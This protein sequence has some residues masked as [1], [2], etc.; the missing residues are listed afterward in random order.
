MA[1]EGLTLNTGPLSQRSER[2]VFPSCPDIPSTVM[3]GRMSTSLVPRLVFL[4]TTMGAE[5]KPSNSPE[6]SHGRVMA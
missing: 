3:C 6:V 4:S 1:S 2:C 5:K